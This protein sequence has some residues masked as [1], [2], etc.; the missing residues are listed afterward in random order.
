MSIAPH[1]PLTLPGRTVKPR[2]AGLTMV[3]DSGLPCSAFE[4]L[5][6]IHGHLIDLLK[7]GWGTAI[8]SRHLDRKVA[9]LRD[10]GVDW[11]F[12][13]T[14]FEIFLQQGKFDDYRRFCSDHGAGWVEVS[15]G[16][17]ELDN[18]RKAEYV[19]RLSDDFSVISEVGY[20]DQDRSEHLPPVRWIRYIKEDLEA[21]ARRVI[22][23]ARES[24]RSGIARPN[25]ELRFGLIEEI[26]ESGI[27]IDQLVFE[28]PNKDLQ[29][30]FV[31][32][33]GSNVNL[34]NIAPA[35]V[36]G[37]ETLRLGL[38]SDTVAMVG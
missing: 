35:D 4:D 20:K 28:A 15:N 7:L 34:G 19:A 24:G 37:L 31:K 25:G 33:V 29:T 2:Q 11:Y 10:A 9:A 22:T 26:L 30:Y 32:R 5:L 8:V 3:I 36:I 38:R 6:E 21:G 13:G 17:I 14:L 27:D 1:H 18:S 23:E 16:T 12:G